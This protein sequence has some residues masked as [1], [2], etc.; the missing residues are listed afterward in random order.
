MELYQIGLKPPSAGFV[1][2]CV[3]VSVKDVMVSIGGV[4]RNE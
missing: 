2:I 3:D 4:A 1:Q